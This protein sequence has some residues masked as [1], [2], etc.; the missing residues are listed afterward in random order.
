MMTTRNIFFIDSGIANYQALIDALPA[1]S[2]W[3]LLNPDQD[4]IEQIQMILSSYSELNTIQILSHGAHG[5]LHLGNTVLDQHN[6]DSYSSQFGHIGKS[7]SP[8]GDL[9]LY[10]C[11]VAQVQKCDESISLLRW[12]PGLNIRHP[13]QKVLLERSSRANAKGQSVL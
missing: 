5:V 10:G 8:S 13:A 9:L 12:R 11:N 2:E 7:L 1:N 3:F 6:I 4:G